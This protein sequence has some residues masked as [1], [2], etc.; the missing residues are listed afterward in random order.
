MNENR[1]PAVFGASGGTGL[2]LSPLL[3]EAG[4]PGPRGGPRSGL[5]PCDRR[6]PRSY[7]GRRDE[8]GVDRA[9]DRRCRS[10]DLARWSTADRADARLLGGRQKHRRRNARSGRPAAGRRHRARN[11]QGFPHA[12]GASVLREEGRRLGATT[13]LAGWSE[14]RGGAPLHRP[15][16]DVVRPPALNDRRPRGRHRR[17][18]GEHLWSPFRIGQ[19]GRPCARG[20]GS[21]RRPGHDPHLDGGV[22]VRRDR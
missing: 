20:A 1:T 2:H 12:S 13:Q 14:A 15:R 4:L 3:L 7:E 16:L 10:R 17:G 9:G 18:L 5:D 8:R 11:E 19:P 22:T 6:A 21:A